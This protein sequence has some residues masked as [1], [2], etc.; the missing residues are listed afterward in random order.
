[1]RGTWAEDQ[2]GQKPAKPIQICDVPRLL[3][4]YPEQ[5]SEHGEIEENDIE[6]L[7]NERVKSILLVTTNNCQD[8]RPNSRIKTKL[9]SVQRVHFELAIVPTAL[10]EHDTRLDSL[11]PAT[12]VKKELM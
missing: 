12:G 5:K 4:G 3:L 6:A 2:H 7:T 11:G 8:H 10:D 1:V 9:T